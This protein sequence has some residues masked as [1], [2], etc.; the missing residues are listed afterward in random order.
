VKRC[1]A[2]EVTP[3]TSG[4]RERKNLPWEERFELSP[5]CAEDA[6]AAARIA[7]RLR[8]SEGKALYAKRKSTVK[9]VFDIIKYVLGF[10]QSHLRGLEATQ[11]E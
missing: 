3:Y 9:T 6:D 11:G 10:R 1:E 4:H 8:T 7:H 2:Y 5:P